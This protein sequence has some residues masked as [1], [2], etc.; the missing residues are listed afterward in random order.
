MSEVL[1]L[2]VAPG[3]VSR[4]SWWQAQMPSGHGESHPSPLVAEGECESLS[5]L[6]IQHP[7]LQALPVWLLLPGQWFTVCQCRLPPGRGRQVERLL[8]ALLEEEL[9]QDIE[10]LHFTLLQRQ[11]EVGQV[12]VI[13][14]A[15]LRTWYDDVRNQGFN[16]QG[17]W[18]DWLALPS[19]VQGLTPIPHQISNQTL[20][21]H[22]DV[23]VDPGLETDPAVASVTV[24]TLPQ[25]VLARSAL[26]HGF[27]VEPALADTFLTVLCALQR[28]SDNVAARHVEPD[29]GAVDSV[30]VCYGEHALP[31]LNTGWRMESRTAPSSGA[32][33]LRGMAAL[34]QHC[35]HGVLSGE[36]APSTAH[37]R[38][39]RHWRGLVAA[40]GVLALLLLAEQGVRLW[41][42]TSAADVVTA[43]A[44][45]AYRELFPQ[46][47]RRVNMRAQLNA[48][49]R[50][51][52]GQPPLQGLVPYLRKVALALQDPALNRQPLQ[53]KSLQYL[54]DQQSL[55][56]QVQAAGFAELEQLRSTLGRYFQVEQ[57][58]LSREGDGVGGSLLLRDRAV[59]NQPAVTDRQARATHR[60]P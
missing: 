43:Q 30:L 16:L 28:E 4:L 49:L 12:A 29:S 14:R 18:P 5:A 56:L 24:L 46:Q 55:R 48:V 9:A 23:H 33:L 25:A 35:R 36:F 7:A 15:L 17:V 1:L 11:D 21:H 40:I 44:E 58:A 39:W 19:P 38:Q 52:R 51:M 59:Q 22:P 6:A 42:L 47:T 13:E 31:T 10:A 54:R 26:G 53:V 37:T 2:R 8:P 27:S 45:Q 60:G 41:R 32:L 3:A 57:G 34:R 20:N 50:Q